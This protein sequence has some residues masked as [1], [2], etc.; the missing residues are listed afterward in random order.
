VPMWQ[1]GVGWVFLVSATA[2]M[3]WAAARVFRTGM[4]HY[5]QPLNFKAALAAVRGN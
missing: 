2:F 5:G 1:I 4:L 3:V